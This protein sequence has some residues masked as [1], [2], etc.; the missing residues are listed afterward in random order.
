MACSVMPSGRTEL[1][2]GN[3][4][5]NSDLLGDAYEYLIKKFADAT[6]NTRW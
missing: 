3:K 6:S 1:L 5:V 2:F 4:N